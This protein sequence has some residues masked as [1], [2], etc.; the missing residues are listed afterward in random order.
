MGFYCKLLSIVLC[1]VLVGSMK[2]FAQGDGNVVYRD[3]TRQEAVLLDSLKKEGVLPLF[4]GMRALRQQAQGVKESTPVNIEPRR[5]GK[6]E[7]TPENIIKAR[8]GG[9]AC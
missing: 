4:K 7:M 5:A 1:S 2:C 3:Y 6:R 9:R 8:K